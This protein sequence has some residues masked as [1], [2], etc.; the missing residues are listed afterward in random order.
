[1]FQP[2]RFGAMGTEWIVGA[3]QG[4]DSV[5]YAQLVCASDLTQQKTLSVYALTDPRRF[6][7]L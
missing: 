4:T 2:S 1:M 6:Q 5:T 7:R 3:L